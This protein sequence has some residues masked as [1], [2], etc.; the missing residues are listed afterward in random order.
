MNGQILKQSVML[1]LIS[2]GFRSH[3]QQGQPTLEDVIAVICNRL[4]EHIQTTGIVTTVVT[5]SSTSGGPITGVGI[6]KV[7]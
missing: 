3:G 2:K 7:A 5:G 4:V 1:D 6:G